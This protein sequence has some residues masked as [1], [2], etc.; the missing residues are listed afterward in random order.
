[1]TSPLPTMRPV[2]LLAVALMGLVPRG[3]LAQDTTPPPPAEAPASDALPSTTEDAAGT[4]RYVVWRIK[5]GTGAG[6]IAPRIERRLRRE[7]EARLGP[8]M[9]SKAAQT[10]IILIRPELAD[11]DAN[12]PCALDV[13]EALHIRFVVGGEAEVTDQTRVTVWLVDLENRAESRRVT[14]PM[15]EAGEAGETALV[16]GLTE[17]LLSPPKVAAVDAAQPP[18]PVEKTVPA[19]EPSSGGNPVLA[20]LLGTG[21]GVVGLVGLV[22]LGAGVV[23]L[24]SGGVFTYVR[25]AFHTR[26]ARD[27]QFASFAVGG[28]LLGMGVL[29]ALGALPL[30]ALGGLAMVEAP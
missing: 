18:T 17:A 8:E 7:M 11:C 9:L 21:A 30:A 25:S 26:A 19:D 12:L 15:K 6:A 20:A 4:P 22:V 16:H 29:L 5:A 2:L 13:A 10:G 3:V 14:L 1:M 28:V 23:G 27:A 24:T